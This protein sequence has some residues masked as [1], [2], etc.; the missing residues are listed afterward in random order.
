M[1]WRL[2][3]AGFVV[4]TGFIIGWVEYGTLSGVFLYIVFVSG[5]FILD[6]MIDE[7]LYNR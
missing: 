4:S 7:R 6:W 1:D 3:V 5:L 2:I